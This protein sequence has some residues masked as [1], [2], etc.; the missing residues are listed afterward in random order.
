[1]DVAGG[2][3]GRGDPK[4]RDDHEGERDP[5]ETAPMA[6]KGGRQHGWQGKDGCGQLQRQG[7]VPC[8]RRL[9]EGGAID[10]AGYQ[11]GHGA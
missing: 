7:D 1:M 4:G 8:G 9:P 6:Q 3:V 5:R 11:C 10:G 2:Q